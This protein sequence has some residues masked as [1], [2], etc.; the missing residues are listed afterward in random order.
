MCVKTKK[1][2]TRASNGNTAA[3][4]DSGRLFGAPSSNPEG[5]LFASAFQPKPAQSSLF[6][7]PPSAFQS[8]QE[9]NPTP[10]QLK[11]QK[12]AIAALQSSL[13]TGVFADS[14]FYLYSRRAHNGNVD[15]LLPV[16]ASGA[17]LTQTA[18]YFQT[19]LTGGFSEDVHVGL[20]PKDARRPSISSRKLRR[21]IPACDYEYESDSDLD[22]EIDD[23]PSDDAPETPRSIHRDVSVGTEESPVLGS[24]STTSPT[25]DTPALSEADGDYEPDPIPEYIVHTVF[26]QDIAY[27]TFKAFVHY[28]YTGSI[29]FSTLRSLDGSKP[30]TGASEVRLSEFACSPKSMY[31]LADKY[32]LNELKE[33]AAQNIKS[34]L[35]AGVALPEL[36]SRFTARYPQVMALEIGFI[37]TP[38]KVLSESLTNL[39]EWMDRV[40]I[41]DLPHA[42]P[43][44]VALIRK[45]GLR[46]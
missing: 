14:Q 21:S 31:R 5:S 35:T 18:E 10:P 25:V 42:R 40:V 4:S 11:L 30:D 19:L 41:G 15:T 3:S 34:Q 23:T 17:V 13:S 7:D 6:G 1:S 20:L 16:H 44:L 26:I 37:C 29:E 24:G 12:A 28:A 33:L 22:D 2:A 8:I 46:S 9:A 39:D 38:G 36:L 43:A 27:R 45:L 32:G